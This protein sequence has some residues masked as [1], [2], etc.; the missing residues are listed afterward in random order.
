[1]RGRELASRGGILNLERGVINPEM[2]L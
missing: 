2:L 1:M